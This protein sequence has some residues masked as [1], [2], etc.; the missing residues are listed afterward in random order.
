MLLIQLSRKLIKY[1]WRI[2]KSKNLFYWRICPRILPMGKV[3]LAKRGIGEITETRLELLF[4]ELVTEQLL[5]RL[6]LSFRLIFLS[7]TSLN[8]FLK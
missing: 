6:S 7:S 4:S 5:T 1:N 3:P 2:C 8:F